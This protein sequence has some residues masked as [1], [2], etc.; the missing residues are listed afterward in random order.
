MNCLSPK[1]MMLTNNPSPLFVK[2]R[3]TN[4]SVMLSLSKHQND[5][6]SAG[7]SEGCQAEPGEALIEKHHTFKT[8]TG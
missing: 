4:A 3:V 7:C 8:K 6:H 5:K 2:L 1:S